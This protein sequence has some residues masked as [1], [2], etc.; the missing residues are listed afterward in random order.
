MLDRRRMLIR[1]RQRRRRLVLAVV[2]LAICGGV[3]L[4][5]SLGDGSADSAASKPHTT[6]D[7]HSTGSTASTP[8]T[9]PPAPKPSYRAPR[10]FPGFLMIADRGNGRALL[11]DGR[12][13]IL[14]R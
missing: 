2:V 8:A 5:L 6:T 3:A 14:W 9:M 4:A 13:R 10:P 11:V 12:R 7:S 1:R